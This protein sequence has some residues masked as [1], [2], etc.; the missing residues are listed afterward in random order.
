MFRVSVSDGPNTSSTDVSVTFENIAQTPTWPGFNSEAY[1]VGR[2]SRE[3]SS[4]TYYDVHV[5]HTGVAVALVT[6]NGEGIEI[7]KTDMPR[8]G[9]EM[10]TTSS[11]V[12]DQIFNRSAKLLP[13]H[14]TKSPY[15]LGVG[16]MDEAANRIQIFFDLMD[17]HQLSIDKNLSVQSPCGVSESGRL[18]VGQRDSGLTAY[19]PSEPVNFL[20]TDI[21]PV[22]HIQNGQSLCHLS[23]VSR[24]IVDQ[25]FTYNN[26]ETARPILAYNS[27]ANTIDVFR[28]VPGTHPFDYR[29]HLSQSVPVHLDASTP[30]SVIDSTVIRIPSGALGMALVFTDGKHEGNHRLLITGLDADYNVLQAVYSWPIGVPSAIIQESLDNDSVPEFLIVSPTSPQAIIFEVEDTTGNQPL[31]L[32][33][34]DILKLDPPYFAEIGLGASM[35]LSHTD[36]G[37]VLGTIIAY[38][39]KGEVKFFNRPRN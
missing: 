1:A 7:F 24:P 18:L 28:Q 31:L 17:Q 3:I 11:P 30:L 4:I 33:R 38:P 22:T 37:P 21:A 12:I 9:G 15:S 5:G 20:G 14:M 6:E 36:R 10:P 19:E 25:I 32:A 27:T 13:M 39:E 35:A 2:Y 29:Y 23:H 8:A 16:I 26:Y 34:L